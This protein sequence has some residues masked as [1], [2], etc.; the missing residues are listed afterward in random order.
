M[1]MEEVRYDRNVMACGGNR[2]YHPLSG[3]ISDDFSLVHYRLSRCTYSITFRG[4]VLVANGYICRIVA[5]VACDV[6][7]VCR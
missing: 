7:T 5:C 1:I 3:Y 4:R 6:Q 2:V